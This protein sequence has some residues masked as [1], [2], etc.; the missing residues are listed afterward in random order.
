MVILVLNRPATPHRGDSAAR[1][2][3]TAA[4]LPP[5]DSSRWWLLHLAATPRADDA[6]RR[7]L[8]CLAIAPSSGAAQHDFGVISACHII[9]PKKKRTP[10]NR[11]K[12]KMHGTA[13]EPRKQN[14]L[15]AGGEPIIY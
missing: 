9:G 12:K 7:L 5:G 10:Y 13:A 6:A 2:L 15:A 8:R 14:K 4:T 1:R 3:R 11:P